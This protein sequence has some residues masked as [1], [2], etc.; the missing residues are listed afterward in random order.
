[1]RL[2]DQLEHF[3]EREGFASMLEALVVCGLR[4]QMACDEIGAYGR[5][6]DWSEINDYLAQAVAKIRDIDRW[7]ISAAAT[8]DE[9]KS[10]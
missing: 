2:P 8:D 9:V 7:P 4:R 5:A 1:M 10:E 3:L 6:Q